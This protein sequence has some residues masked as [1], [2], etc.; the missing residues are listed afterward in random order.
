MDR[1]PGSG[2]LQYSKASG[3]AY[4]E[5]YFHERCAFELG[6]E[7]D[8]CVVS[9]L[10]SGKPIAMPDTKA[11][12]EALWL[13]RRVRFAGP[14]CLRLCDHKPVWVTISED[15]AAW[16]GLALVANPRGLAWWPTGRVAVAKLARWQGGR[17]A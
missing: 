7:W 1:S 14:E 3:S 11:W 12:T 16:E 2:T 13:S 10:T 15:G 9:R 6:L 17:F 4:R 8:T 5:L